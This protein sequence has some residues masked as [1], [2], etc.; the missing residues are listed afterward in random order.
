M[1]WRGSGSVRMWVWEIDEAGHDVHASSVDDAVSDR[2]RIDRGTAGNAVHRD[3]LND[4]VI[5]DDKV[6]GTVGGSAMARDDHRVPDDEAVVGPVPLRGNDPRP[7][8]CGYG[9]TQAHG[10]AAFQSWLPFS[11]ASS[12]A[13]AAVAITSRG[14]SIVAAFSR[15]CRLEASAIL[16][17]AFTASACAR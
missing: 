8:G 5:L 9:E 13:R 6:G 2:R 4:E 14:D 1:Y 17:S 16:P 11:S 7:E 3:D 15:T 10:Q 12:A